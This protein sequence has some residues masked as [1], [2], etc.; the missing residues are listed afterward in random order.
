MT[1]LSTDKRQ[2]G[3]VITDRLV[4]NSFEYERA[5]V[6]I[7]SIELKSAKK[8]LQQMCV[9]MNIIFFLVDKIRIDTDFRI[10]LNWFNRFWFNYPSET[11]DWQNLKQHLLKSNSEINDSINYHCFTYSIPAFIFSGPLN[12]QRRVYFSFKDERLADGHVL[13]CLAHA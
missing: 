10:V 9:W 8:T 3:T 11:I 5:C 2:F 13:K 7:V 12:F 1:F 6:D 4:K